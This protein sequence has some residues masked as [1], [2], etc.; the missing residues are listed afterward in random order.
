MK[1]QFQDLSGTG[2]VSLPLDSV[3][4]AVAQPQSRD[5]VQIPTHNGRVI[6][7]LWGHALKLRLLLD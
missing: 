6:K 1:C 4:Q 7:E 3:D 2:R 5:E